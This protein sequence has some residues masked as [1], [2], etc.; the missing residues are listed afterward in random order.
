MATIALNPQGAQALVKSNSIV[1]V[2]D[3]PIVSRLLSTAFKQRGFD[4]TIAPDGRYAMEMIEKSASPM[5]V[6]LD[7]ILP[8]YDGFEILNSIRANP[9]WQNVPIIM[10]T[11]KTQEQTV[12]RAF[13]HGADDYI[14]KPF[15]IEELMARVRRLLK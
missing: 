12:V 11:S 4:V 10:L 9:N 6:L 14:T 2:E 1:I 13:E 7:I 15:Q 5:L 8:F 3:D